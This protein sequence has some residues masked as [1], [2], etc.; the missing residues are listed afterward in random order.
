MKMKTLRFQHMVR[1]HKDSI[2]T[3]AYYFTGNKEDAEDITQEV[4][5]RLWHHLNTVKGKAVKSWLMKVTRNVC[6]DHSRRH[7]EQSLS[8][9]KPDTQRQIMN[10]ASDCQHDP[11]QIMIADDL[12]QQGLKQLPENFRHI[13][14]MREIQ[15]HPNS[16]IAETMDLPLNTVKVYLHRGRK[17]L[18][19]FLKTHCEEKILVE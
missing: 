4:L 6:I 8:E 19:Q 1:Q 3:Q 13:V 18:A 9:F 10:R 2:Y 15:D 12:L 5:L 17:L 16:L 7:G 11:E 14:I